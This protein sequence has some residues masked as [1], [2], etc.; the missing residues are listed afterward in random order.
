MTKHG[1]LSATATAVVAFLSGISALGLPSAVA[2]ES[3]AMTV[4]GSYQLAAEPTQNSRTVI[5]WDSQHHPLKVTNIPPWGTTVDSTI[6][7]YYPGTKHVRMKA[8]VD[9]HADV[10]TYYSKNGIREYVLKLSA[11]TTTI[12]YFDAT[13]TK[14]VLE[15][16]WWRHDYVEQ[17]ETKHNYHI[18]TITQMDDGGRPRREFMFQTGVLWSV[19]DY[20]VT[21]KGVAYAQVAYLYDEHTQTLAHVFYARHAVTFS[22]HQPTKMET[23]TPE[24]NIAAPTVG[25]DLLKIRVNLDA[26]ELPA[27]PRLYYPY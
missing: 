5:E 10:A 20:H 23:H 3:D 15:Q 9:F 26:D 17:G 24:E 4:W 27:P 19:T 14:V 11:D 13:G 7:A 22:S 21:V 2:S 25:Q 8:R 6:C 1:L 18:Y 12:R 16:V